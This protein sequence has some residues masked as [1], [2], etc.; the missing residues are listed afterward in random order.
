M[1]FMKSHLLCHSDCEGFYV[2]IPF[3]EVLL[4]DQDRIPGG[5]LGS[6]FMLQNELIAVAPAL[7][8]RLEKGQLS[9][10][11]A[12]RINGEV[13]TEAP[14]WIENA[15]WLSLFEAA[16]LSLQHKTAICFA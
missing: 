16:R 6:S 3:Q 9:N 7:G 15:V 5:M 14:L 10:H 1:S 8:I 4:D 2:P 11:E 12:E 13:E